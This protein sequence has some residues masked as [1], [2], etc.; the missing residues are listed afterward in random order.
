[1]PSNA[2]S[3]AKTDLPSVGL[4]VI[5]HAPFASAIVDCAVHVYT[6]PPDRCVTI[7]VAPDADVAAE[8]E[9]ARRAVAS[10]DGGSGVLVLTDLFG[11]TPGNIATE[12]AEAGRVEVI[13][14]INLPMLL[15]VLCY[16]DETTLAEMPEK[17]LHGG[18]SGIMKIASTVPPSQQQTR[19]FPHDPLDDLTHGDPRLQDQ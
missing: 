16:R 15:R 10:V 19:R 17:A 7:D 13:A 5:A 4:V 11:A 3:A 2:M 18:V 8:I 1:M 6:C 14:G 12:L 9:R